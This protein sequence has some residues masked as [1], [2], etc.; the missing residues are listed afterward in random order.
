ME[1][2]IKVEYE[3]PYNSFGPQ[4]PIM[5]V[6]YDYS[7]GE[8]S[9]S[10]GGIKL[11]EERIQSILAFL[12]DKKNIDRFFSLNLNSGF[13]DNQEFLTMTYTGKTHRISQMIMN[14]VYNHPFGR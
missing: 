13:H 6:T 3:S 12:K 2:I 8:F 5:S 14:R 1:N 4:T 7:T 11:S 9:Y 10:Y